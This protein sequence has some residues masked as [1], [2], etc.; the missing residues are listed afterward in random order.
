MKNKKAT[1]V[2][3]AFKRIFDGTSRRP[4][5]VQADKGKEFV[6]NNLA[7]F[8]RKHDIIFNTTKNEVKCAIAER[9]IK[10]LKSRIFKYLYYKNSYRYIDALQTIC[11]AYNNS[12]HRAIKMTPSA[13]NSTNILEVYKNLQSSDV[14]ISNSKPKCKMGDYVRISKYKGVFDKGYYPEWSDEIFKIASVIESQPMVYKIVDLQDEDIDGRFYEQE[15]QKVF[16]DENA[17][18]AIEKIISQRV[19]GRS[20][21]VLVKWRGYPPKFNSW[22]DESIVQPK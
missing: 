22:V 11:Y 1:S 21:Q 9:V 15:I 13:V 3:K 18:F 12:Y 7:T 19:V 14:K 5:R 8:F 10:T 20:R 2:V 16:Y 17:V 6:N 4:I